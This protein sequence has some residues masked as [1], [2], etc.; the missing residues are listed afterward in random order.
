MIF[1]RNYMYF[2]F[3]M[4]VMQHFVYYHRKQK[5]TVADSAQHVYDQLMPFWLKSRLP[6]RHK[7]N[8]VLKIKHLYSQH[9]GLVK[10]RS[11]N[12]AKDKQN[13]KEYR[14]K[15]DSLFDISIA[16]FDELI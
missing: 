10:H 8:I 6:V 2:G 16:N 13:Q 15:L 5:L 7:P 11:R 12:N 3:G 1:A 4:D 14:N 9:V